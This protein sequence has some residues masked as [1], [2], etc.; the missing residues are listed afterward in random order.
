MGCILSA[1]LCCFHVLSRLQIR[2]RRLQRKQVRI[3]WYLQRIHTP[4]SPFN[5]AAVR[6]ENKALI[7]AYLPSSHDKIFRE[8]SIHGPSKHD[9]VLTTWVAGNQR[10]NFVEISNT[11]GKGNLLR[12][13]CLHRLKKRVQVL[14]HCAP[15]PQCTGIAFPVCATLLVKLALCIELSASPSRRSESDVLH[16]Y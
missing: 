12:V 15:Q 5:D 8:G 3:G 16:V 7:I 2:Y 4:A 9:R 1:L 11:S 14:R 13:N 6:I 10:A